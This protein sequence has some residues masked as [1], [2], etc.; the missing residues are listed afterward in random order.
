MI[1]ANLGG[2]GASVTAES[3]A[4]AQVPSAKSTPGVG[5]MAISPTTN[6]SAESTNNN[7]PI[8]SGKRLT[9]DEEKSIDLEGLLDTTTQNASPNKRQKMEETAESKVQSF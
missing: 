9:R 2:V 1:G 7:T 8:S 3:T 6:K 5:K 4:E